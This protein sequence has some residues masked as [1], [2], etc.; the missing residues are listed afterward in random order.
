MQKNQ[1]IER[2][3]KKEKFH[4]A[5]FLV[6]ENEGTLWRGVRP[7]GVVGVAVGGIGRTA[8]FDSF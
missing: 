4:Q 8:F 1:R 6:R 2:N 5:H 3:N 7:R